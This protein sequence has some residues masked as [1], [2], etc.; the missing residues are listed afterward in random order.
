MGWE[1]RAAAL[2]N[3]L[4]MPTS[5]LPV[6]EPARRAAEATALDPALWRHMLQQVRAQHPGLARAWFDQMV[7]RLMPNGVIQIQVSSAAQLHFC[8]NQCQQ[9]FTNSAQQLTGRLT[10]VIFQFDTGTG[11][12]FNEIDQIFSLNPDYTFENFVTGPCNRLAHAASIAVG[13]QPGKAYNP[14]FIHGDVGLG[15][16]HLL[17]AVCQ[18][19][20]DRQPDAR[21]LYLSCDSFINQFINAVTNNDMNQF[22]HRYRQVDMLVIDDIH[23]LGGD[24][25]KART[26]EEFF[27]TFNTLYQ[28]HKQI[29]LSADC[30]PSEIPE[31]EDRLVS[32]F[33][34]GLVARID[35]PCYET[36]MAI[37]Q[38]KAQMRGVELPDDVCCYVAGKIDSNTREL[39]GAV[40]KIQGLAML[41]EGKV[42]L[43]LA[44][45]AFG[46]TPTPEQ[47][48][49]TFQQIFDVVT[50]YYNVRLSDLQSKRRH[51]SIAFPRQVCMYLARKYT[52]YSLEEIGG[53]FGGR[54]HTTVLHAVRTVTEDM[55]NE[56]EVATQMT[57]IEGQLAV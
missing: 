1:A 35:K 19:I 26:Q 50:K 13:E 57:Q 23:F 28:G 30:P 31:L 18:K 33:N 49:I 8:Q 16:T 46:D 53:H 41:H 3:G 27:H 37:L 5:Q 9:A 32:R 54:D 21:I 4:Y 39:E 29:V 11:G 44:K 43:E 25:M 10:S 36:R 14:L 51:K 20:L 52:K 2:K 24:T 56:Q 12:I 22:R 15:K 40:T 42:D 47:R 34:W 45:V 6:R 17:Q 38:K 55:K 7:P 48:R